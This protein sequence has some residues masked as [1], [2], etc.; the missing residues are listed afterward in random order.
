MTTPIL[1]L[2]ELE[3]S[4]SQPHVPINAAIRALE[5]SGGLIRV[6]TKSLSTPPGGIT[7]GDRHIVGGSPTDEWANHQDQISYYSGGIKFLVPETGWL[8]YVADEDTYYQYVAGSPSG[9]VALFTGV[10]G[11]EP[12]PQPY[13]IGAQLAGVPTASLVMLR[14]KFP[15]AVSFPAGLTNS[16]GVAGT[17][18]TAQTD[19]DVQKNGVSI[20]TIRFAAAATSATF[21][22]A[23]DQSFAQ[24]DVMTIVAPASPDA[25]LAGISFTLAGTR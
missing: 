13:D 15:R 9:W 17:Q 25:T 16:Q 3:D 24:G 12:E 5:V 4:Q 20:G 8:A 1:G 2:T 10:E 7:E 21:I 18:A 22:M 19:F 11:P 23:S 6:A 14:L